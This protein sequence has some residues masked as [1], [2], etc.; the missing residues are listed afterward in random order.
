[1][2]KTLI[3]LAT[4]SLIV[5][6]AMAADKGVDFV[7]TGKAVVYYQTSDVAANSVFDKTSSR[8]NAGLQLN[9]DADLKNDFT[10]GSQINYLG[11]LG[12]EK[13]VVSNTM[14]DVQ[15]KTGSNGISDDI[16]LSQFYIAKKIANTT[17]KLGRQELPKSLS[18][19]AFSEDWNVFTNTFDAALVVNSDIPN[20]TLVGAYVGGGNQNGL[21]PAV[22]TSANGMAFYGNLSAKTGAGN[23]GVVIAGTAYMLT[24]QNKSLP[25][26]TITATYYD[27]NK[28]TSAT[29]GAKIIWGDVAIADNSLPMGLKLGVQGGQIAPDASGIDSTTAYGAMVSLDPVSALNVTLAYSSVNDGVVAVKNVGGVKTPLYTQMTLNQDAIALDGSTYMLKA[30]YNTGDYGTLIA[31][32]TMTNAGAANVNINK[33]FTDLELVYKVKAANV[34]YLAIFANTKVEDKPSVNT[35]R[36]V[37]TYAF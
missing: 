24:A 34:N 6:S 27:V 23:T 26:A 30:A 28:V 14:Q 4:A 1:M 31:Q 19:F 15:N 22:A 11:T 13:N 18:P 9:L 10:F 33:D 29:D 20:T 25:M 36:V 3:S 37:A 35:V 7:T 21:A 2:K 5:S 12:L 16:Y 8:A 32:G 17:V